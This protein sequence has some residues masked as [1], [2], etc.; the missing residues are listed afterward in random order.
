MDANISERSSI[1]LFQES[2][3][4]TINKSH[5]P[6]ILIFICHQMFVVAIGCVLFD[7]R[8][9]NETKTKTGAYLYDVVFYLSIRA[10]KAN[11]T[12]ETLV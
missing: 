11:I 6:I 8:H 9:L 1:K 7:N 2:A 4:G 12:Y 3:Y 10:A 5:L